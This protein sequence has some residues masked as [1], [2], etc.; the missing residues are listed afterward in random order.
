MKIFLLII[1]SSSTELK[2][3]LATIS[4][5]LIL[6]AFAVIVVASSGAAIVG[7]ALAAV[8]PVTKLIELFDT[9]GN[10]TA[11]IEL[12]VNWPAKGYVTDE[13]GT[14]AQFRKNLGLGPHSGIDIGNVVGTPVTPFMTGTIA[15]V[16]NVDDSACGKAVKLNHSHNITSTYCHM[17]SAVEFA[18]GTEVEPG[19]VIGYIGNTGESTGPH[20]HFVTRVYGILVNPR[21][22]MVGEPEQGNAE[23]VVE[24]IGSNDSHTNDQGN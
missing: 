5:L 15:W 9:N 8:N 24:D 21:T 10:K 11:E 12:S 13:F 22:F 4:V 14:H 7:E 19:V 1:K 6:P 3:I 16:D 18:P 23:F 17:D 20:L 2:I